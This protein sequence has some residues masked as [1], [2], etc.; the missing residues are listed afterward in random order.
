M[1]A[2]KRCLEASARRAD[3]SAS[4]LARSS[5]SR[6]ALDSR[7]S[8]MM[9]RSE[10]PSLSAIRSVPSTPSG[11]SGGDASPE[12]LSTLSTPDRPIGASIQPVSASANPAAPAVLKRPTRTCA[13]QGP[14]VSREGLG[15]VEPDHEAGLRGERDRPDHQR[16]PLNGDRPAGAGRRV[17]R[18]GPDRVRRGRQHPIAAPQDD[19]RSGLGGDGLQP[20]GVDAATGG[21]RPSGGGG[22]AGQIHQRSLDLDHCGV[23]LGKG[24]NVR[25]TPHPGASERGANHQEID[26]Q[27]APVSLDPG[28][29]HRGEHIAIGRPRLS[30]F[31][32]ERWPRGEGAPAG[33]PRTRRPRARADPPHPPAA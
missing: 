22:C 3:W 8:L 26:P 24:G 20:A 5:V 12:V 31:R 11:L 27:R 2:R 28:R 10:S 23:G 7:S 13:P 18:V 16:G 14:V 29:A 15:L 9:A 4:C 32:A 1:L 19:L 21:H 30:P 6:R 33:P 17:Q 25:G